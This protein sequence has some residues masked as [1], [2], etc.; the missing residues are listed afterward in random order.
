MYFNSRP[1]AGGDISVSG[2]A[3]AT[4]FNSRPSARGD[5]RRFPAFCP[6]HHISIHAPPRGA[7]DG[8]G[9]GGVK[10]SISIHAPPRG[11]TKPRRSANSRMFISIH[12]PPRGATKPTS[13]HSSLGI[14]F[15]SRPSARGDKMGTVYP[16]NDGISIHAPP[17]GATRHKVVALLALADI[18]IH[19][20]P[21]G[22]TG[23]LETE[24][25]LSHISIHAP[26]RGATR[27]AKS[28]IL[29]YKFQF[30]PL[31][32]GRLEA[33]DAQEEGRKIS[34]HAPPRGA[35]LVAPS[36]PLPNLISIHAPPR[37]A[38]TATQST[39]SRRSVFQFTPLREGRLPW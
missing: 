6:I 30:T 29:C 37:G 38:T 22:A 11:A 33:Q 12:A 19:A 25:N 20:P 36:F 17:R 15:N 3:G 31:R 8:C 28:I 21:R 4:D 14:N 34:I 10:K 39:T 1:S 13:S 16:A 18:S 9:G 32:E 27:L 26:P 35:T 5:P 23:W 7:T 24:E 2:G